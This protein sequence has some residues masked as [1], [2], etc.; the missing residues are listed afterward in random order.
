[1]TFRLAAAV[2]ALL[3][4]AGC[5]GTPPPD[6]AAPRVGPMP[7]FVAAQAAFIDRQ[8]STSIQ[9]HAF[10]VASSGKVHAAVGEAVELIPAT[11][12]AQARFAA[13]YGEAKLRPVGLLPTQV[14]AADPGYLRMIR[15][16]RTEPNGRFA[17]DDVAPGTY[18]VATQVIWTNSGSLGPSGGA[19]YETVKVTGAESRPIHLVVTGR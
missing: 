11:A 1:M 2:T 10:M 6:V 13:L 16:T 3:F 8:G 15:T 18:F 4:L 17:F 19:I 12:Y 5:N 14:P 9:G 7:P